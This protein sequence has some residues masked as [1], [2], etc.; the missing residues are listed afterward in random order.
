MPE[1]RQRFQRYVPLK[2]AVYRAAC[3]EESVPNCDPK[4]KLLLGQYEL[5][6]LLRAAAGCGCVG[7]V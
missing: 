1:L 5:Q 7:W 6:C 4:S 3:S 2:S